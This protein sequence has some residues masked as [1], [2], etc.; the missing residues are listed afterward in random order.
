ML[1]FT[2][3]SFLGH[4]TSLGHC[5]AGIYWLLKLLVLPL[6]YQILVLKFL[7]KVPPVVSL[8][9]QIV[10]RT[11]YEQ[12]SSKFFTCGGYLLALKKL[13]SWDE[14]KETKENFSVTEKFH[15]K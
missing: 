9:Y 10:S 6:N 4:C 11:F 12:K 2:A 3:K 13:L 1:A 8:Y 14:K 5:A 15:L 7:E